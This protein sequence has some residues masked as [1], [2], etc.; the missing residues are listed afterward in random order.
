MK[1]A[2]AISGVAIK[3]HQLAKINNGV[4]IAGKESINSIMS[5]A[6]RGDGERK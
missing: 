2:A 1:S 5:A 4:K 3:N 6:W